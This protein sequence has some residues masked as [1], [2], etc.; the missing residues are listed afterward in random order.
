MKVKTI[1]RGTVLFAAAALAGG[2]AFAAPAAAHAQRGP[3]HYRTCAELT[4]VYHHGVGMPGA[5]DHVR[6]HSHPVRNFTVNVSA[7]QAN[8]GLDGDRDGIAC[9]R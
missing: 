5:R 3:V 4:R 8:R 1:V 6:G 9:E 7:Y 2:F